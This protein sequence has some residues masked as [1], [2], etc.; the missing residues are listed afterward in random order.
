MMKRIGFIGCGNMGEALLKGISSSLDHYHFSFTEASER[1]AEK[2]VATYKVSHIAENTALAEQSD[3]LFLCVKPGMV[4][5]VLS[6][7]ATHLKGDVLLVS[8]AA[9]ISLETMEQTTS[10]E[11][12]L[13]RV[14]PN[15]P[16]LIGKG[17]SVL[18][19]NGT[20]SRSERDELSALFKA[21]GEVLFLPE[22]SFDAVTAL[23]GSGPAYVYQFILALTQGGVAEGLTVTD[24]LTLAT[25]TVIGAA[26][27]VKQSGEHPSVLTDRV[28]SP[29]GTTIAA[30]SA[31]DKN[32]FRSAVT[33]GVKAAAE[34]SRELRK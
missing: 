5:S 8:I 13:V 9:G 29:G 26:E 33:E 6:E 19:D 4:T 23:S 32:G 25:E 28:T 16:A 10:K 27:L 15:T 11:R 2:I 24:A 3:I 21:V 1:Q 22:A 31:L 12:K 20:L 14:M 17:V 7:I 30:L 18:T 34:R